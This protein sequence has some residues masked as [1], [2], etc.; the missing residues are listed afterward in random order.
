MKAVLLFKDI[1][2]EAFKNLGNYLVKHF[3]KVFSIVTLILFCMVL[4]AFI[5]RLSTGFAF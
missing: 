4:Y 1:Y 2:V 3:F 5:Y